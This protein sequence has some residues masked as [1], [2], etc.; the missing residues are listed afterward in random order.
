MIYLGTMTAEGKPTHCD[1]FEIISFKSVN[2]VCTFFLSIY[3]NYDACVDFFFNI[4]VRYN[5]WK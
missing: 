3:N 2:K 5:S 1:P 4:S